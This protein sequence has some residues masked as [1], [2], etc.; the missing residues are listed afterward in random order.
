MNMV[1]QKT[2]SVVRKAQTDVILGALGDGVPFTAV[3]TV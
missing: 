1:V 2:V 3:S